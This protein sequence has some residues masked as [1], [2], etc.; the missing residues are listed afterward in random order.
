[1]TL[2]VRSLALLSGLGIQHCCELWCRLQTRLGSRVALA[3]APIQPLAWELAY[4][5]GAAKEIAKK[6][7]T[8]Q[9]K[10]NNKKIVSGSVLIPPRYQHCEHQ[11]P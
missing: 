1:M 11:F 3:T 7:K 9:N 6:D 4:A 5:E 8:K 10:N 2:Q